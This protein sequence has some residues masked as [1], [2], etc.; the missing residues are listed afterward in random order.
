MVDL[1][2][3]P[4]RGRRGLLVVGTATAVV[5]WWLFDEAG[6]Q[7]LVQRLPLVQ[8]QGFRG[9]LLGS[10]WQVDRLHVTWDNGKASLTVQCTL[11]GTCSGK[12]CTKELH[13]PGFPLEEFTK[14]TQR[15][16]G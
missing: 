11:G 12:P 6:S 10:E 13:L 4:Q 7:W 1:G 8:V 9:S 3:W 16:P 5:R 2:Q 14:T 15:F